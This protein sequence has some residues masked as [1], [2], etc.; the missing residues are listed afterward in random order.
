MKN[1]GNK[2]LMKIVA[3]PINMLV[4]A[5]DF[6]LKTMSDYEKAVGGN[7][8]TSWGGGAMWGMP[9][10]IGKPLVKSVSGNTVKGSMSPGD[11][12]GIKQSNP[13]TPG[14][15]MMNRKELASGGRGKKGGK[16]AP[17]K[18]EMA[19][20]LDGVMRSSGSIVL[21]MEKIEEDEPC[22]FGDEC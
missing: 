19:V 2:R 22:E 10:T 6:Y 16:V 17:L 11:N 13:G 9:I 18:A 8:T 3:M 7:S 12:E 14:K 20:G 15:V 21:R 5:G 4:K 1:R